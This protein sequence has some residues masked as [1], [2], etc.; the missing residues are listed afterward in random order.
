ME[1]VAA[2]AKVP[3]H[4][5]GI[6]L[7]SVPS[8]LL[9]KAKEATAPCAIQPA[10]LFAMTGDSQRNEFRSLRACG[11]RLLE[12]FRTLSFE[13]LARAL[14]ILLAPEQK[15]ATVSDAI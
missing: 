7:S 4:T 14:P 9:L 15:K 8:L 5:L 2:L 1:L 6:R 12:A 10:I 3:E 11:Q 13:F